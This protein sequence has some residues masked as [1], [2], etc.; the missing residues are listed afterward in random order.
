MN[1]F[2]P[3]LSISK[4][5]NEKEII[6]SGTFWCSMF[7]KLQFI[8]AEV[9][10]LPQQPLTLEADRFGTFYKKLNTG[11]QQ[12]P[13]NNVLNALTYKYTLYYLQDVAGETLDFMT[14]IQD[15]TAVKTSAEF[16]SAGPESGDLIDS[17]ASVNTTFIKRVTSH[18]RD[19]RT[20]WVCAVCRDGCK[21]G[22]FWYTLCNCG[23]KFHVQCIGPWIFKH[24]AV[25]GC[26]LC[27]KSVATII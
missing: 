23:H 20:K 4:T 11:C 22:E 8:A 21:I 5:V 12:C 9:D 25:N 3:V 2:E 24:G 27:R 13:S 15:T 6:S 18:G 26:P 1:V 10:G 14:K 7:H 17:F 19:P 16:S